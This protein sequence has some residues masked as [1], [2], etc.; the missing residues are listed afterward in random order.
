[1]FN[2]LEFLPIAYLTVVLW[3]VCATVLAKL[4]GTI[5][6]DATSGAL[7]QLLSCPLNIHVT[8]DDIV[9]HLFEE[10]LISNLHIRLLF[11]IIRDFARVLGAGL[12]LPMPVPELALQKIR[13]P[14]QYWS[15]CPPNCR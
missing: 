11:E 14:A 6:T 8:G 15:G 10:K 3:V 7:R 4:F 12:L 9:L 5:L 2:Q 1:M 13:V